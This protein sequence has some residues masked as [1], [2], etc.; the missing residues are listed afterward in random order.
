MGQNTNYGQLSAMTVYGNPESFKKLIRSHGQLCK[1]KQALVCPCLGGNNNVPLIDCP[2]CNGDGYAFT[3]QRRFMVVDEN[4]P[5]NKKIMTPYFNPILSVL[6]IE[7]KVSPIQGGITELAY[8]SFSPTEIFLV[9]ETPD[10]EQKRVTYTFDGWTHVAS[11]KLVVD[12]TNKIMYATGTKFNAE[13]Q[14]SNPLQA[15]AD[16]AQ[17]VRVWNSDTGVALNPAKYRFEGNSIITTETIVADKMYAEYYYADLTQVITTDV[18]NRQTLEVYTQA[19]ATGECKMAFY[20]FFE[21][22]KGDIIVIAAT[23]LYRNEILTHTKDL[24]KLWEIEIFNLNSTIVDSAGITYNLDTDYILQGRHI[25]WIGNKPAVN[26]TISVRYGYKP[27]YIV[28]EDNPQPLNL[29][30]KQYPVIILAK[31][32]T[33]I[34][35]DDISRLMN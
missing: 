24:D 5:V 23:V 33:K 15:Y 20:P 7:N 27:A 28:F 12:A 30:N 19:M 13:Y 4:S 2:I 32:W 1:V 34:S 31:S 35:K 22:S 17:V 25:K 9:N 14:S 11:E 8:T 16:I 21:L 29:E 6:K 10:E 26:A 18:A 3:Y